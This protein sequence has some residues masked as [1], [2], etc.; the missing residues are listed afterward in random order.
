MEVADIDC[1]TLDLLVLHGLLRIECS[2]LEALTNGLIRPVYSPSILFISLT[3]K[4]VS[5]ISLWTI[6]LKGLVEWNGRK[7]QQGQQH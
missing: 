6:H 7:L 3:T 5:F 2:I 4:A 1:K